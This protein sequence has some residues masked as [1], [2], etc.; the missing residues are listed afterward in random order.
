MLTKKN[1]YK[2]PGDELQWLILKQMGKASYFSQQW[3]EARV[4]NNN[5]RAE[6]F[7]RMLSIEQAKIWALMEVQGFKDN[8]EFIMVSEYIIDA[9][10][11][12]K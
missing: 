5:D 4:N 12:S 7:R 10:A 3:H 6:L 8:G 9:I 11:L 2:I 1:D